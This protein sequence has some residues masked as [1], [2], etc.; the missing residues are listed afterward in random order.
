M[1]RK[2]AG[3]S[4]NPPAAFAVRLKGALKKSAPWAQGADFFKDT[5]VSFSPVSRP[6]PEA[7]LISAKHIQVINY[8]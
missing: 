1:K 7:G 8:T 5:V 3:E 4:E 6:C 2:A